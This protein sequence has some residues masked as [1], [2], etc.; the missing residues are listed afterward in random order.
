MSKII[1]ISAGCLEIISGLIF[2]AIVR[3]PA[4]AILFFISG[5][6]FVVSG[7][8]TGKAEIKDSGNEEK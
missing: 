1:M 5:I 7:L 2:L 3:F 4:I 6:L 8:L